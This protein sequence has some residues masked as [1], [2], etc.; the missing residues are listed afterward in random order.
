MSCSLRSEES[1]E[2]CVIKFWGVL[3]Q[4]IAA[5]NAICTA[6][7]SYLQVE[8]GESRCDRA[9]PV[10]LLIWIHTQ[11]KSSIKDG[12]QHISGKGC[13]SSLWFRQSPIEFEDSLYLCL[14]LFIPEWLRS[15]R[16]DACCELLKDRIHQS[17]EREIVG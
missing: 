3:F 5:G 13:D 7:K 1:I 16:M 4:L 14:C 17:F 15:S 2:N 12:G 8:L 10:L 11:I 6:T 9:A